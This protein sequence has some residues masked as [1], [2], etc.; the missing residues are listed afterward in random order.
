MEPR[1]CRGLA[2]RRLVEVVD[3]VEQKHRRRTNDEVKDVTIP[4]STEPGRLVAESMAKEGE[5]AQSRLMQSCLGER[6]AK[7]EEVDPE[8]GRW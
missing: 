6:E 7:P 8:S 1:L 2:E 3:D 4:S 5:Q